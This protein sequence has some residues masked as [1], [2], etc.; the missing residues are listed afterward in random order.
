MDKQY[1]YTIGYTSFMRTNDLDIDKSNNLDLD[2]LFATLKE[3]QVN[4]LCDVRSVPY[5]G[6]FPDANAKYLKL[7]GKEYGIPYVHMPELGAKA[8]ADQDV[9]S[10]ACEVFFENEVFPIAKSNRPEKTELQGSDE[11]VDFNKFRYDEFFVSG[12]KRIEVAYEKG[13]TLCLMCSEKQPMDCHRY[14]LIGKALHNKFSDW[15]EV[16]HI[17]M[18][19]GKSEVITQ[20][21]LD[22]ELENIVFERRGINK[23]EILTPS[24]FGDSVL[25]K[26]YGETQQ[27]KLNDYCDR[28]WNLRH[29]WK[30]GNLNNYD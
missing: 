3:Y 1:L 13:F 30:K 12:L 29:G 10:P 7:K 17:V 5:S 28:F 23:D 18:R 11:I 16:R 26:Y 9:F 8:Q 2:R 24:L 22:S 27:E 15:L 20:S 21:Q 14:F 25:D 4:Y 19:Q 6:Q